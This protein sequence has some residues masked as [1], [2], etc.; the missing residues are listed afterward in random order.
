MENGYANK[1]PISRLDK[2]HLLY[3]RFEAWK[4]E[5][6]KFTKAME[7]KKEGAGFT[8]HCIEMW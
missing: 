6:T 7:I 3:Q 5:V 4:K 1:M 2:D 8:L